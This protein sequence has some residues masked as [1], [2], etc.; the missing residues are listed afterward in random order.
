M[1]TKVS[2]LISFMINSSVK[3]VETDNSTLTD[4]LQSLAQLAGQSS[5]T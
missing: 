2:I 3:R 5:S 1:D 4:F